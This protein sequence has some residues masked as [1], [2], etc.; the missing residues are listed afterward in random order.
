MGLIDDAIKYYNNQIRFSDIEEVVIIDKFG[1][2]YYA[3]GDGIGVAFKGINL[4]GAIVT[5]NHPESNGIVS[6]GKDDFVFL[7]DNVGVQKL[8]AVNPKYTYSVQITSDIGKLVYS[9]YNL[10][11]ILEADPT[12]EF[13]IQHEVFEILNREGKVRYVR[14]EYIQ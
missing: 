3:K 9:D 1:E 13:D 7:R 5:H 2:V 8:F 10:K 6:F 4:N 12:P 14:E 11:A